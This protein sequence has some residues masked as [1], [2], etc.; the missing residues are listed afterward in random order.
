MGSDWERYWEDVTVVGEWIMHFKWIAGLE[1]GFLHVSS[2]HLKKCATVSV[3]AVEAFSCAIQTVAWK[4]KK[5]TKAKNLWQ[6]IFL[7]ETM[8]PLPSAVSSPFISTFHWTLTFKANSTEKQK[9]MGKHV[10]Q[11][12]CWL[13]CKTLQMW[14]SASFPLCVLPYW[15]WVICKSS[16]RYIALIWQGKVVL[17]VSIVYFQISLVKVKSPFCI[18]AVVLQ[19]MS[20][21][22]VENKTHNCAIVLEHKKT[23][24]LIRQWPFDTEIPELCLKILD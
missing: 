1:V 12:H 6:I 21:S 10:Q 19:T 17:G 9:W 20:L 8:S 24:I 14:E 15:K 2:A 22:D 7:T 13:W 23:A 5:T 3:L 11:H 4:K 18:I 16:S